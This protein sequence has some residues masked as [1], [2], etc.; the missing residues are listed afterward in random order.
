MNIFQALA[1]N[2]ALV[3]GAWFAVGFTVQFC[4]GFI[5]G[6]ILELRGM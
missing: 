1:L 2:I 4:I 5:E 3:I 6:V